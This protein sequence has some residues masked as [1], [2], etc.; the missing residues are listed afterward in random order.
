M[1]TLFLFLF[2]FA[3]LAAQS[4]NFDEYFTDKTMRIDY[5]HTGDAKSEI[6]TPDHL[7][8]YGIWAGSL[9]NLIDNFNN[10]AYYYKIF[11]ESS[12]KLIY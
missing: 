8:R 9:T 6:V 5:Y 1:K 7:Y 10:G 3:Q 2:S 12:R 4:I 11:D